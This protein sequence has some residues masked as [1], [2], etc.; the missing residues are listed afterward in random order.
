[1]IWS[2]HVAAGD[3][4]DW[5]VCLAWVL[6]PSSSVCLTSRLAGVAESNNIKSPSTGRHAEEEGDVRGR[7][8]RVRPGRRAA[9]QEGSSASIATCTRTT[10]TRQVIFQCRGHRPF[11][12]EGYF[13]VRRATI[14]L[15]CS[16]KKHFS[17]WFKL[18]VN[19]IY[20]DPMWRH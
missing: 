14:V 1:M 10:I 2:L 7:R 6:A 20:T 8:W 17:V 12:P 18:F 9:H 16:E 11:N 13:M 5:L 19:R 4:G 15:Y 3:R